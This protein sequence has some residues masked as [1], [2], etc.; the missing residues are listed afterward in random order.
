[1]FN[2]DRS[3]FPREENS[4]KQH[5]A[6]LENMYDCEFFQSRVYRD[7]SLDEDEQ[8]LIVELL[9]K[10]FETNIENQKLGIN[11]IRGFVIKFYLNN[12]YIIVPMIYTKDEFDNDPAP[13]YVQHIEKVEYQEL[14]EIVRDLIDIAFYAVLP[15]TEVV[16]VLYNA[17][18][19]YSYYENNKI[20]NLF[21]TNVQ[22][23]YIKE[24]KDMIE[25]SLKIDTV[26]E[27]SSIKI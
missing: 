13:E 16:E 21:Q 3:L 25:K 23:T 15:S 17:N 2:V 26:K 9:H 11:E 20:F 10:S 6:I 19:R 24:E 8:D 5:I 4:S 14:Y 22:K 12:C 18:F 27:K 1:M 7:A